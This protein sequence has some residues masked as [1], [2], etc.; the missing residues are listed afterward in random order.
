LIEGGGGGIPD[1]GDEVEKPIGGKGAYFH[2]K[3]LESFYQREDFAGLQGFDPAAEF[4]VDGC[5]LGFA[6]GAVIFQQLTVGGRVE[7]AEAPDDGGY[8]KLFVEV[9]CIAHETGSSNDLI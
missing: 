9:W 2:L 1:L 8:A 6:P 5:G 4:I 7:I 3:L